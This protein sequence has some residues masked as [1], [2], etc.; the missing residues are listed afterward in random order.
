MLDWLGIQPNAP[1]GEK[2]V[3]TIGGIISLLAI[4]GISYILLGREGALAVV[5][6]MGAST[7][8]LFAVPHGPLSQPWALFVGNI[9]SAIVGVAC[10]ML[11]PNLIIAAGIAVGLAIGVMHITR[12]T[13]PPGGATALAAV[14]GGS[15]ITDLGFGYVLAPVLI[16]CM[17]IF[18]VAIVFNSFFPWRRYPVSLMRY[19]PTP[20]LPAQKTRLTTDHFAQGMQDMGQ[21]LDISAEQLHQVYEAALSHREQEITDQFD[22]HPGGLYTNNSPGR[23]W[24]IRRIIDF[25]HHRDPAKTTI[26]YKVIEGAQKNTTNSCSLSEFA[27]WA[28]QRLMPLET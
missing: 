13:H 20:A 16:N 1:R 14:I 9:S 23:Q 19:R 12:S 26:I 11:I 28:A 17:V 6:S 25:S 7:V 8:L 22:F 24:A 27:E 15:S 21:V 18:F 5:P 3:A 4:S 2:L 10:A